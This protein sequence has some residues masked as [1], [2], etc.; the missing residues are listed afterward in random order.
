MSENL[1]EY[2][3]QELIT[4]YIIRIEQQRI[5]EAN[6]VIAEWREDCEHRH[7]NIEH[8]R[9]DSH[10]PEFYSNMRCLVCGKRWTEEG[11]K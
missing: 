6:K 7:V 2:T 4:R 3:E 10:P 11:S 5:L 8:K 9:I 1:V